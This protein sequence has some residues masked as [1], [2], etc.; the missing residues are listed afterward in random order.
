MM[1]ECAGPESPPRCSLFRPFHETLPVNSKM[2]PLSAFDVLLIEDDPILK[3]QLISVASAQGFTTR[4]AASLREGLAKAHE[5]LPGVIVCDVRLP[6]GDGRD[7]LT[8]VRADPILK[9]VQF[10]L[11]TGYHH[12]TPQ[13]QGMN[14][15]ADDYLAKPFTA[16]DY[17]SCIQSRLKRAAFWQSAL[18]QKAVNYLRGMASLT[19]PHEFFT[20]L[21]GIIGFSELLLDE[22]NQG[23]NETFRE[24]LE[25]IQASAE[26]LQRTLQNYIFILQ[27]LEQDESEGHREACS[28]VSDLCTDLGRATR[29]AADRHARTDDLLLTCTIKDKTRAVP[30]FGSELIKIADEL[31]DNAFKFSINGQP[32]E[33]RL[34]EIN[35]T[36]CLTVRDRGRGLSAAQIAE[37]GAFR[38]F[39]RT[40]FEQQGLGL[41]L[42]IAQHLIACSAGRFAIEST[43]QDGTQVTVQWP[44]FAS[45]GK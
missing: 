4:W 2:L 33:V 27:I 35:E 11:M 29:I 7:F 9:T 26:R 8:T 34:A 12:D 32:V 20:P 18:E 17:L 1:T 38:Q 19:L 42:T 45:K 28:A 40:R 25:H 22:I 37:I 44:T 36:L 6:D 41:G 39:N 23:G 13:R 30:V 15:G 10:V 43:P 31:I 5:H 3:D 14:L 21:A 16:V 24:P